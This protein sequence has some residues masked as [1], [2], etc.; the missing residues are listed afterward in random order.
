MCITLIRNQGIF[1][2]IY[3]IRLCP[4]Q[5]FDIFKKNS[6]LIYAKNS[7]YD[8]KLPHSQT[9][10]KPVAPRRRFTQQPLDTKKTNKAK[11][12]ALSSPSR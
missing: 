7:E 10:D 2:I 11:Q 4:V 3:S 9:A 6:E 8:Q 12:P 1:H 5:S